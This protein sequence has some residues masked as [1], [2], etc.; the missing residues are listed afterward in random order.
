MMDADRHGGSTSSRRR[1]LTSASALSAASLVGLLPSARAEPPPEVTRIRLIDTPAI[2]RAPEY[3]AEELLR[4]EGFSDIQ[5]VRM[6]TGTGPELLADGRADITMW[7][8]PGTIPVLDAGKPIV[9]LS[10]VHAGCYEL[11]GSERVRAIRDLKGKKVSIYAIGGGDHILLSSML[12]YVGMDP[13]RDVEWVVPETYADTMRVFVEGQVDAFMAFAPQ[14]QELRARKIGWVI[15]DTARDRPWSQYFCCTVSANKDFTVRYPI[16]TKRALRVFL[17]AAD[18]CSREPERAA[19]MLVDKGY[20]TRYD[21]ALE[22]LKGLPYSRWREANPEDTLRFHMLRL[23]EVGMI[24]TN[25]NK[26]V[27]QGSDWRFLNELKRELKT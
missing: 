25:P 8:V 3:L 21:L 18:I 23:H 5:H 17:K 6:E 15:V 16:A 19:R 2:C 22:V 10:G 11:I 26:L 12:A 4:M 14:P 7:D 24:H 20:E 27:A 9:V 13:R 1:F